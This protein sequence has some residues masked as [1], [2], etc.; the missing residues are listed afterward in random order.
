M[1]DIADFD[2]PRDV[3]AAVDA[4]D[5]RLSDEPHPFEI[6]NAEAIAAN[7]EREAAANPALF[8]GTMVLLSRLSLREG[9]LAGLCHAVRYAT[10]LYWRKNRGVDGIE[11]V[12]AFPALVSSD[13]ALVAIR[14][15]QHTANPGKVYFAAGSFEPSDFVDGRA[16]ADGNM[17]REVGE[18][19]G[20]DISAVCTDPGF[21]LFSHNH[22]T[23]MFRR[24]WLDQ[25]A[26][27]L[28]RG[29]AEF[30]A[31]ETDPEIDGPVIIR[32]ARDEPEGLTEHMRAIVNWHFGG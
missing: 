2:L 31:G 13:N 29:I 8:N 12:F 26:G 1:T 9:K 22:A 17:T 20:I 24:Y 28:A 19:T 32:S 25:D 11:H 30:V 10:M 23:V 16:D 27:T 15:G 4:I 14:M 6:V 18:E 7:W 5:V 3:V 21:H